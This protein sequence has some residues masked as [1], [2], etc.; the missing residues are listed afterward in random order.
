MAYTTY[1]YL[2][3]FL[4]S[5]FLLYTVF[6]KKYKW[7]V[8]LSA[9]YLY[10]IAASRLWLIVFLFM[11]TLT[12]YLSAIW[13]D[14]IND[15]FQSVK[16][17]LDR[18]QKK[19]F[20][21]KLLWQKKMVM[22]LMLLINIGTLAFL[23]YFNFFGDVLNFALLDHM[24]MHIPMLKLFLPLGISFYTLQAV[25]YVI[26][27]YRG[28]FKADK[29]FGR[30]LLFV[31]FFPQIIEGPIGRYDK[32]A[33]QLYEGHS[34]D[35]DKFMKGLQLMLWGLIKIMVIADRAGIFVGNV[36]EKIYDADGSIILLGVLLYTIQLY[37]DFSGCMDL[38]KGIG[39]L[40]GIEMADNFRRPFFSTSV[41]E[42][43][44]R[45]HIT[46]GAWLR[47]YIFYPISL[48]KFFANLSA[49]AK[50]NFGDFLA[51]FLPSAFALFFVWFINGLWHG[52]EV[53]YIVYGL[54]YYVVMML[55][56]LFEPLFVKIIN[57]LHINRKSKPYF[58]FQVIRTFL[59]VNLGM[60]IFRANTLF[61][62]WYALCAIF[63]KFNGDIFATSV[64]SYKLHIY[65]FVVIAIGAVTLFIVGVLQEKG[66]HL[67]DEIA[68]RNIV[69]RW[70][71]Y[72]AA[73]FILVIVGAYGEG[74]R[75]ADFLY[76]QF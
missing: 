7:L 43:W 6:P 59:L 29:N 19:S 41:N 22:I 27:V 1:V 42:F 55:G 21:E 54:Y 75:V 31:C 52:A 17:L 38:V 46:L 40:F 50:K 20:K 12:V 14:K 76:A 71:I 49:K 56:L 58:V 68:K 23:K 74:Y 15:L 63:S 64:L 9:S 25:S 13:L 73:L 60:L 39:Q 32:L 11:T 44:R 45:W 26:D 16:K 2:I 18:D 35:Y 8:L 67:R 51:K 53:K 4:G 30:V 3:L 48:S 69:I 37:A 61:D 28:T 24:N 65:D 33:G 34:F 57:A 10:Y 72:F 36:F 62:A 70:T 5:T 47:D 66:H